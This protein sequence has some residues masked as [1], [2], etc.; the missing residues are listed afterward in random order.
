MSNYNKHFNRRSIRHFLFFLLASLVISS[1]KKEENN[2]LEIEGRVIESPGNTPVA[3]ARVTLLKQGL[4]D[5]TFSS[6]Y[7]PVNTVVTSASGN[8]NFEFE[9]G[10]SGSYKLEIRK[11]L[12]FEKDIEINPDL[13]QIGSSYTTTV[14]ISPK[15]WLVTHLFNELPQNAN[16]LLEFSY[17]N[18]SFSC[19]CCNSEPLVLVGTQIDTTFTCLLP[20]GYEM[21]YLVNMSKDT[22]DLFLIDSIICPKF[23]TTYINVG[24]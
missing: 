7:V 11:E 4:E 22:S 10:N 5:G 21:K 1:C 13:V 23:D 17:I 8:F 3:G 14:S 9:R 24:Y 18:A 15:A 2:I 19:E 16:D 12:Y 6:A 20:G